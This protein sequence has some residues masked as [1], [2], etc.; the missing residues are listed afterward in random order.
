MLTKEQENFLKW[1][2]SQ[3]ANVNNVIYIGNSV[4]TYPTG[5]N[6][7][8]VIQRL[9]ELENLSLIK[10]KWCGPHHDNLNLAIDVTILQDGVNYFTK[11]KKDKITNKRD[12]IKT[13]IPITISLISL[14]VSIAA[15]II[16]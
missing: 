13:Y 7:K 16:A 9:N 3:K 12:W 8:D 10:I 1:L 15:L 2:L 11:K 14:I 5:Y 4:T 6:D